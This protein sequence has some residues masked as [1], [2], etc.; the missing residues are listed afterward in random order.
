MQES[1]VWSQYININFPE[2]FGNFMIIPP[3]CFQM[4]VEKRFE[5]KIF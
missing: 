1:Y 3:A 4:N 5:L 2:T